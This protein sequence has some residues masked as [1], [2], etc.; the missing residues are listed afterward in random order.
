VVEKLLH[1]LQLDP[2]PCLQLF[3]KIDLV[4]PDTGDAR[5]REYDGIPISALDSGTFMPFLERA[6]KIISSS[7]QLG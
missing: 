7:I 1:E 6:E 4:D 5:I 2:I 3:N